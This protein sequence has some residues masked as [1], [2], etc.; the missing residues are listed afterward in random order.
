MGNCC[1]GPSTMSSPT[2][3][4][5]SLYQQETTQSTPLTPIPSSTVPNPALSVVLSSKDGYGTPAHDIASHDDEM[6]STRT[7]VPSHDSA[8]S[9]LPLNS[10]YSSSPFEGDEFA[11][12]HPHRAETRL[13]QY[14]YRGSGPP[15]LNQSMSVDTRF[16]QGARSHSYSRM[17]TTASASLL[18]LDYG[19]PPT[20]PQLGPR[21]ALGAGHMPAER[22]ECL[23]RFPSTLRSRLSDDFRFNFLV[24]GKP[25]S[26]KSSLIDAVFKVDMSKGTQMNASP[27]TVEFRPH[28]NHHLVVYECSG[29]G[30]GDLQ[31]IR[32]YITTRNH[33]S[34]PAS[35][36]LHA[37]WIC[38]P[39]L[40][41]INRQFDESVRTLLGV[42][43]PLVLVF[44]KF[45]MI[46]PNVSSN[47]AGGNDY[48]GASATA[49][50]EYC[51]SLFGNVPAEIVS[52]RP[53]FRDLIERLVTT[54]DEVIISHSRN[55][56]ASSEAQMMPPR[57]FPVPLAWSVSQRT[58]RDINAQAAIEVG[59]SRYWCL[60]GSSDDF[61][62]Q[63]LADCAEVIH[64]D[65]VDVWNLPDEDKFLSSR[66]FKTGISHLV[67]DLSGSQPNG[68]P[69]TGAAWL[70]NRYG[71][72]RFQ[73]FFSNENIC[74]VVGYIVDLTLVLCS[75]FRFPGSVSPSKVQSVM[76][77]FAGSG[78][79]TSIHAE[80]KRFIS[81][82][83]L[84]EYHNR[85]VVLEKII[86]LI[87]QYCD[88]PGCQ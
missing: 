41:A 26:G 55:V 20:S 18:D 78:H 47:I 42:G 85:D 46:F 32:D 44:T 54:T 27:R 29:F 71:N 74:I 87:R 31:V 62:G 24:V 34:R 68:P 56:S 57:I 64:T 10:G 14:R 70:N 23:P 36:R 21:P 86:D 76:N 9:H 5:Q 30:P 25:E 39:M 45:D 65:I 83:P 37:I 8:S 13:H 12:Q 3:T 40:D 49:Y 84:F 81:T 22:H 63:T 6:T 79:K 80:I 58:S 15:Q 52:T 67:Q 59:R 53:R 69:G 16:P 28:E 75:V 35:E 66:P 33:K 60:L 19:H 38:V 11:S 48:E 4:G 50:E 2:L 43:V 77:N 72:T 82:V 1:S 51:R 17:D 88:L 73:P 61:A 7:R